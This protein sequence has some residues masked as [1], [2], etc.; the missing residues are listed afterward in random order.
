MFL[1]DRHGIRQGA[2]C[3]LNI[4]C[5]WMLGHGGQAREPALQDQL[6]K[7]QAGSGSSSS[8]RAARA[9]PL[10]QPGPQSPNHGRIAGEAPPP[11]TG[12]RP[13]AV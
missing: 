8:R 7:V 5:P 1:A 12:A 9:S 11:T 4:A 2:V 13:R 10:V 3:D 6:A